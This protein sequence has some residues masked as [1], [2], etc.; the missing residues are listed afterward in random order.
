MHLLGLVSVSGPL[1]GK[2]EPLD[3]EPLDD[4]PL[5]D[6][7]LDDEPL[8]DEPLDD[9][10]LDDEPLDD[11]PLDDEP[12]DDELLD[13]EPLDDEL[14][15]DE[16]L[17]DEPLDDEPLDDELIDDE[18]LPES[19]EEPLSETGFDAPGE[20]DGKPE[21]DEESIYDT[22]TISF[23]EAMQENSFH[24]LRRAAG[25]RAAPIPPGA[26]NTL[27]DVGAIG[28]FSTIKAG[29]PGVGF[30]TRSDKDIIRNV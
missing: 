16:P 25:K 6:E 26:N 4:E 20:T 24:Q 18:P 1:D 19:D 28:S 22:T 13:D 9:E 29:I 17:D 14:L 3:D 27:F 8:D 11:E 2:L 23:W 5:D 30:R 15:D 10:Q 7:P 21:L 12:L